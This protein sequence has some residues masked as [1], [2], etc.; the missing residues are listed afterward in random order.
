VGS[1]DHWFPLDSVLGSGAFFPPAN[2]L[3]V[4][5]DPWRQPVCVDHDA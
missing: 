5:I 3:T 1:S 4:R 2:Y